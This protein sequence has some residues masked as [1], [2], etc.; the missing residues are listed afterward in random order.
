MSNMR[1][2]TSKTILSPLSGTVRH[3]RHAR[4]PLRAITHPPRCSPATTAPI[5][6]IASRRSFFSLT[7]IS[8]LAS[9]ATQSDAE[10]EKSIDSDGEQQTFHARK[11][12]PSA[13]FS[14]HVIV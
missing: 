1:A 12:L 14:K 7:D 9:F 2:S 13:L 5:A 8:K 11:I 10:E 3:T 6:H 4:I